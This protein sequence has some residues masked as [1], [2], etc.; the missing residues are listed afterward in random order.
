MRE[1]LCK[2][3]VVAE[4]EKVR[5]RREKFEGDIALE[6]EGRGKHGRKTT[7]NREVR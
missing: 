1:K 7:K 6:R 2:L 5:E 3:E 4:Q